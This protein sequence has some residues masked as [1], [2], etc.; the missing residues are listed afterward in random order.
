MHY[1]FNPWY[2]SLCKKFY[3]IMH[4]IFFFFFACISTLLV[5]EVKTSDGSMIM[6]I[7]K[8]SFYNEKDYSQVENRLQVR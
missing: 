8:S 1:G 3:F 4:F 6:M 5:P 2:Q 7:N